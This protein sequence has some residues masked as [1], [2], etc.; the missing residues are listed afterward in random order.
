MP[1]IDD[2]LNIATQAITVHRATIEVL[3]HNIANVNTPGYSR[4]NPFLE[5]N[6][7]ND[8][9]FGKI[10]T[11]VSL[12]SVRREADVFLNQEI[13]TNV[14]KKGELYS[15]NLQL[16]RIEE[17][18]NESSETGLNTAVQEFFAAWN[19]LA[20]MP[21]GIAEREAVLEKGRVLRDAFRR[22]MDQLDEVNRLISPRL[23]AAVSTVNS[24]AQEI[25]SLN[26]RVANTEG[27]DGH[28]N[29]ERD[30]REQ[31]MKELSDLIGFSSYEDPNTGMVTLTVGGLP[32]VAGKTA[33]SLQ[34]TTPTA[35]TSRLN[36]VRADGST[37]EITNLISSGQ[38]KGLLDL[39][40]ITIPDMKDS[41]NTLARE[42][43][44]EINRVHS[45]GVGLATDATGKSAGFTS[46]TSRLSIAHST[47]FNTAVSNSGSPFS[48]VDG[49]TF[50][51]HAYDSNGNLIGQRTFTI[52]ANNNAASFG[53][54]TTNHGYPP[55]TLQELASAVNSTT[56]GLGGVVTA[57][58]GTVGP[59]TAATISFGAAAGTSYFTFSDDSSDFLEVMGINTFFTGMDA[60]SFDLNPVVTNDVNKINAAIVDRRAVLQNANTYTAGGTTGFSLGFGSVF[61][62][63]TMT[64]D[65]YDAQNNIIE[66]RTITVSGSTQLLS[67]GAGGTSGRLG[68]NI[69][70]TFENLEASVNAGGTLIA[71]RPTNLGDRFV[72]RSSTTSILQNLALTDLTPG[73]RNFS[74]GDNRNALSVSSLEY[75]LVMTGG[76][77]T[78]SEYYSSFTAEVGSEVE[79]NQRNLDQQDLV[80]R[81]LEDFRDERAGVNLDEELAKLIKFEQAYNAASQLVVL[82]GELTDRLI[83]SLGAA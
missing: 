2:I 12:R 19:D 20:N 75:S 28:A 62:P 25:A 30:L 33:G 34:S 53:S 32:L 71:I 56:F 14:A 38:I 79:N 5:N 70:E 74:A 13:W 7:P 82:V 58:I 51:I 9:F 4:Q 73:P 3:G 6:F 61:T 66:T 69:N 47:T 78:F 60:R 80:V 72:I 43:I 63:G 68:Y 67:L 35:S 40:N 54:G 31:K 17:I 46:V 49:G 26:V 37:Q 64:I 57:T 18:F 44:E 8:D 50:T 23:T 65:V 81:Q 10:G 16:R 55:G 76:T 1:G 11:G 22:N 52:D 27:Q 45:R 48:L 42:V 24:L 15:E 41:L 36:F 21:D 29:D 59:G 83:N 77:Q 39:R